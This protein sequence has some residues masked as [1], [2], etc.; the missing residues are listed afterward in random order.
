MRKAYFWPVAL[1]VMGLIMLAQIVHLLPK[2]FFNLWPLVMIV[3]GLGGLLTA[4]REEWLV[5]PKKRSK[6]RRSKRK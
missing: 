6:R 4:D 3:A 1:V 5:E 2:D